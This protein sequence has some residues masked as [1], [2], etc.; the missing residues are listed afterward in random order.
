MRAVRTQGTGRSTDGI[1]NCLC[2][3]IRFNMLRRAHFGGTALLAAVADHSHSLAHTGRPHSIVI[4]NVRICISY[5][6]VDTS[7]ALCEGMHTR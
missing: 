5:F 6:P 7:A 4:P 1:E 3:K 2:V